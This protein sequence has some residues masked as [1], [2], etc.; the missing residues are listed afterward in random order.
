MGQEGLYLPIW[1]IASLSEPVLPFTVG[2][3]CASSLWLI[4]E[5]RL[6]TLTRSHVLQ[7][8]RRIQTIQKGSLSIT[9]YLQQIKVVADALA[10]AGAPLDDSDLVA[11]ILH[12]LTDDYE[13]L[14]IG[15]CAF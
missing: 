1:L 10:A 15:P 5:R 4:L 13:A 7:L 12:G 8:K 3:T 9:D 11:H 6:A 14:N 2:S